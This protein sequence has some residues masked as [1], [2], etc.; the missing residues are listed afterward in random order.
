[1]RSLRVCLTSTSDLEGV[2]DHSS[3]GRLQKRIA[4]ILSA[5]DDLDREQP[6]RMALLEEAARQLYREW[7]VAYASP[8]T[9]TLASPT[10]CGGVERRRIGES[11]CVGGG[12]RRLRFHTTGGGHG[13]W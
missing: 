11:D 13:H 9:S 8:A 6:R 7:F 2:H 5:Y 1:M 12:T 4:D 3:G 10:A